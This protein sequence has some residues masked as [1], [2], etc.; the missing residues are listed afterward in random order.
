M[1]RLY[2][3]VRV[4]TATT[5]TG[6]MTLGGAVAGFLTFAQGGVPDGAVVSYGIRDGNNSEVGTGTYTSAS[7]TLTRGVTSSTNLNALIN[8]SGSAEVYITARAQDIVEKTGDTMTGALTITSL[9][10]TVMYLNKAPGAFESLY[11]GTNNGLMRW[12]VSV[13]NAVA[14]TG[15]HTGSDFGIYRYGDAGNLLGTALNIVRATGNVSMSGTLTT[16]GAISSGS[17]VNALGSSGFVCTSQSAR[18]ASDNANS[19]LFMNE[20]ANVYLGYAK[21]TGT[22]T[23]FTAANVANLSLGGN[24]TIASNGYSPGGGPWIA[25]SDIRIKTV[26]GEYTQGLAEVVKLRPVTYTY[27]GNDTPEPPA[28]PEVSMESETPKAPKIPPTVPY[29]NSPHQKAAEAGRVFRGL[30]AQEVETVFPEMVTKREGYI[31]GQP[32]TDLRD[33]DTGPLIFALVNAVKELKARVEAL[34]AA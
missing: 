24:W 1:P 19:Y 4:F 28:W 34:E 5:G 32:V 2:N 23:F 3:L 17:S 33:L 9:G 18:F 11:Y 30:V 14:E 10:S 26:Q 21:A 15:S 6:T 13:G 12:A 27:K 29:P 7:G 16:S 22:W 25:T 20:G 31:D 8:L